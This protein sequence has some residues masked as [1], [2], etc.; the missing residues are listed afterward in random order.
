MKKRL[1]PEV[2]KPLIVEAAAFI[3]QRD[4]FYNF[5]RDAVA[6]KAD[7]SSGLV[8]KHFG[9]MQALRRDVMRY[10]I[11]NGVLSIIAQ[12]LAAQDVQAK[13]A[14]DALKKKALATLCA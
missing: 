9:T 11:R 14:P 7:I 5:T 12:G 6:S 2:R 13:K 1:D 3:A 4:G 10:A 8:T